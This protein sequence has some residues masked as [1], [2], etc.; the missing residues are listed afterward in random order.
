MDK[1]YLFIICIIIIII[2][3]IVVIKLLHKNETTLHSILY[4]SMYQVKFAEEN[5]KTMNK[6]YYHKTDLGYKLMKDKSMTMVGLAYNIGQKAPM[7]LKRLIY[8]KT[9]WKDFKCIIYCYD[10]T[11]NT[12]NYFK[13]QDYDW[14]ILPTKIINNKKNLK[15][16]IRMSKLRNLCLEYLTGEE[17]YVMVTDY[18]LEG[19]ISLDGI[20]NSIYYLENDNYDVITAN[21]LF[22]FIFS[23]YNNLIGW[24]YYDP[25]AV[26]ELNGYR[27]HLNPFYSYNFHRGDSP[28]QVISAFGGAAIYKSKL[29]NEK[30]YNY[31]E[32]E[33][34]CEHVLLHEQMHNDG[35]KIAINPSMILL[36]GIQ[37]GS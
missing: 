17:D 2:L 30:K 28:Y 3:L 8:L 4:P 14:L 21:G 7:L 31:P 11:D 13:E 29:F 5:F 19:P 20:A 36:S 12:Y 1:L 15:R 34:E 22:S 27:P 16:F 9:Y 18:D 37:G 6:S 35:Y 33:N 24:R 25:L 32:D 26:K 23:F 10:S